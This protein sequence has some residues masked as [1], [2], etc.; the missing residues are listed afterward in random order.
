MTRQ[1]TID[2]IRDELEAVAPKL[3][4]DADENASLRHDLDVDSLAILEFIAR[5]E[6][7]FSVTVADED[8]PHMTTI[9]SIADYLDD[10]LV[11]R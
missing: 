7:R 3:P 1:Q 9:A 5:L 4:R 2:S 8:W 10:A 6:Y 11:S